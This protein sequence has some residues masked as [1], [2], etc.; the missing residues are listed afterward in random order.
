MPILLRCNKF[1]YFLLPVIILSKPLRP[2]TIAWPMLPIGFDGLAEFALVV[3]A[4][5]VLAAA[6]ME[7]TVTD[8]TNI[9]PRAT[10]IVIP[11]ISGIL[12][13]IANRMVSICFKPFHVLRMKTE[14]YY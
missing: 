12:F 11:R 4:F 7:L 8:V 3:A 2:L 6:R 10:V 1:S 14:T 9:R 5:V 13:S